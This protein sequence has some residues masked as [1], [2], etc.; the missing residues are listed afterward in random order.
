MVA[1][2]ARGAGPQG[3]H[4]SP[5]EASSERTRWLVK[6][7]AKVDLGKVLD[8]RYGS[9]NETVQQ[10]LTTD[11]EG[12]VSAGVNAPQDWFAFRLYLQSPE[13][14]ATEWW[15]YDRG[16]PPVD[17]RTDLKLN[18]APVQDF[19]TQEFH[20][21]Q[22][23]EA[24]ACAVFEGIRRAYRDYAA[25]GNNPHLASRLITL[26]TYAGSN[27]HADPYANL[28]AWPSGLPTGQQPGTFVSSFSVFGKTVYQELAGFR[29]LVNR[30]IFSDGDHPCAITDEARAF[31]DGWGQY[32]ARA[33]APAPRCPGISATDYRVAGNVAAA[34]TGLDRYCPGVER[35][36]MVAVLANNPGRIHSF[37]D[38]RKAL[39]CSGLRD[40]VTSSVYSPSGISVRQQTA[41]VRRGLR[42]LAL[43]E[44]ALGKQLKDAKSRARHAPCPPVPCTEALRRV[45]AP[46]LLQSE[47]GQM[48]ALSN[49]LRPL[50]SA[51]VLRH[52]RSLSPKK[53]RGDRIARAT[54]FHR[55][56]A[57]VGATQVRLAL[58]A[59]RRILR[60]DHSGAF[61]T[62]LKG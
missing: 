45:V 24:Q 10:T 41:R 50:T 25:N 4:L 46:R 22:D 43:I 1:A 6:P 31:L 38:F 49:T 54:L 28:I 21:V 15:W 12:R 3:G 23:D 32:W 36:Q 60:R 56:V 39:G 16:D 55:S 8:S 58:Q 48:Q 26:G 19:G 29:E 47:I 27:P 20:V 14:K 11:S 40:A 33:Y 34:L 57:K 51:K 5:K 9:Y 44:A 52:L 59:A 2:H 61:T 37:D 62:S 13:A 35:A 42:S 30:N 7:G 18:N 53:L 17:V